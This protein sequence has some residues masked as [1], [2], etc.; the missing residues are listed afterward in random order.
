MYMA[1][2]LIGQVLLNRF[3]VDSFI[4][5]GGMGAVFQVWDLS[6][7]VP[8]AMKVL[9]SELAED[10]NMFNRFRREAEALEKLAHP[11]IVPFYGLYKDNEIVFLLERYIDGPS[12]KE[13][14]KGKPKQLLSLNEAAIYIKALSAALGYAHSNGVVHCD[15]KPG[16]V[17]IDQG[18][19]VFVTDFGVARH[20]ESLVTLLPSMGTAAYMAP[21]QILGRPVSPATDVYA[22]GVILYELLLGERPFKGETTDSES[23]GVTANERIRYA[24]LNLE[25]PNPHEINRLISSDLSIVILK[26]LSKEINQRYIS[27]TQFFN[28]FC[29]AAGLNP[30]QIPDRAPIFLRENSDGVSNS[31][32]NQKKNGLLPKADQPKISVNSFSRRASVIGV[33]AVVLVSIFLAGFLFFKRGNGFETEIVD[34]EKTNEKANPVEVVTERPEFTLIPTLTQ[35]IFPSSTPKPKKE[36]TQTSTSTG[37]NSPFGNNPLVTAVLPTKEPVTVPA[38]ASFFNQGK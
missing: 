8:L 3:R 1:D 38:T 31:S 36:I 26:A 7:N 33:I 22:L 23:P 11:N 21:E 13:I 10:P 34:I 29:E 19:S 14:L 9:H 25:A 37:V 5:A 24:H 27:A 30:I 17:M 2:K 18:G 12:L 4:N 15:V 32:L 16:N 35:K 20:A 28:E 6:R